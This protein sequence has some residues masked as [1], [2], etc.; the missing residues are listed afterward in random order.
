MFAMRLLLRTHYQ[1]AMLLVATALLAK[2]LIPAGYM[3]APASKTFTVSICVDGS[4]SMQ[5]RAVT[6]PMKQ[7]GPDQGDDTGR[8]GKVCAY[9]STLMAGLGGA[10]APVLALAFAF[11]LA[12]GFLPKTGILLAQDNHLR[13][14][15]RGPPARN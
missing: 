5:S 6:V 15:L 4:G 12:L 1:L 13:P 10:D 7:D 2:A 8:A 3:V 9:S 11:I 14:P